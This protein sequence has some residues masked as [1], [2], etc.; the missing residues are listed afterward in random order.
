MTIAT[1]ISIM[2]LVLVVIISF[3]KEELHLGIISIGFAIIVGGVGVGLKG[4]D[5]LKLFPTDLFMLLVGITYLYAMAQVNGTLSKFTAA[6]VRFCRGNVL[7]I[8]VIIFITTTFLTTIGPGNIASIAVIA[9][10]AMALAARINMSAFLMTIL[11]VGA[12]NGAALSP[13]AP[14]GIISN[15]LIASI[16]PQI[17]AM[18]GISLSELA[19]K[20]H[21]SSEVAQNVVNMGGFLLLGGLTWLAKN[22]KGSLNSAEIGAKPEPYTTKQTYTLGAICILVST[23]IIAGLPSLQDSLAPWIKNI[24]ANVG[25][26]SFILAAILLFL[27]VADPKEAM[28]TVPWDTIMLVCGLTVLIGVMEKAG[29]LKALI[30]ITAHISTPVTVNGWLGLI[31]GVISTYSS[32]TGVVMPMFLP[33]VPGLIKELGGGDPLA[34]ISSINI[35]AH[36]VDTSPLSTVGALCIVCAGAHENRVVLFRS[37]LIWG[38]AMSVVGAFVTLIFFGILG[39]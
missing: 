36:L 17:P 24:T 2:A 16:A 25:V 39:L 11:V 32:S 26:I 12:A 30:A 22:K 37:L 7:L 4:T 9:P 3:K 14:A 5:V 1:L 29:G 19:W 38:L 13:F 15:G 20:I 28:A 31:T 23:V 18:A 6:V 34:I 10:L 8:V 27:D 35:G 21:W 33:M